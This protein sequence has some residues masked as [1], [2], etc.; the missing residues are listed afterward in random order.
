M[1]A[2]Q[3]TLNKQHGGLSCVSDTKTSQI[4]A[5]LKGNE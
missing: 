2:Q 3:S 5:L 1:G 4:A